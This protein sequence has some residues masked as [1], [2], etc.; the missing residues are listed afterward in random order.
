MFKRKLSLCFFVLGMLPLLGFCLMAFFPSIFTS[1]SPKTMFEIWEK[2]NAVHIFGTDDM[3]YDVFAETVY[4]AKSTITVGT[5][6][7]L[8]SLL[9]GTTIGLLASSKGMLGKAFSLLEDLFTILPRFLFLYILASYLEK[10]SLTLILLIGFFTW[11]YTG[12]AVKEESLRIQESSF[13]Q[14]GVVMGLSKEKN[15][16]RHLLPHLFPVLLAR[17]LVLVS[18][19]IMMEST[20]SF[21]GL[22]DQY[23]VS[24]GT[25]INLVYRNGAF[26]SKQY[27]ALLLPGLAIATL[28]L[29]FFFISLPFSSKRRPHLFKRK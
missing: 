28:S 24:W 2:P 11:G 4:G 9:V 6:G 26:L 18:S 12:R 10:G 25:L 5:F 23:N 21:L 29:S 8:L 19:S 3:G 7:A 20:L 1:F 27:G 13:Y 14:N 17:F 16:I 15:I 22:G